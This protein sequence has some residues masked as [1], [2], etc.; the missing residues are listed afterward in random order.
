MDNWFKS[1]W[2]VRTISLAFAVVLYVFV[3]VEVSQ[4][5]NDPRIFTGNSDSIETLSDVPL[6]IRI[7]EDKYV[8]SGVPE[9]VTVTLEGSTGTL[10]AAAKQRNFD[11][12][13]NLE[14]LGEGTHTVEVQAANAPED[15]QLYIE[16]KTIE[17]TIKERASEEFEVAV[18]FIN[19]D[20]LPQGYEVGEMQVEPEKVTI[21]SSKEIIDQIAIVKVF[22]DVS[23]LKES[24]DNREVP[25]NVYNARGKELSVRVEPGSV[26]VSAE[27]RNPSKTVPVNIATTGELPEGYSLASLSANIDEVK[28]FGTSD[29][30]EGI[31]EVSTKEINLSDIK[32]SGTV[33][34]GLDLP[35]NVTTSRS[36]PIE[37]SIELEQT[38]KVSNVPINVENAGENEEITFVEPEQSQMEVTVI[39]QQN[40]IDRLTAEDIEMSINVEGL[41]EG[42]HEVPVNVNGPENVEIRPAYGQVTV[43]IS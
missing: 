28:I 14:G 1:P 13:V 5:Q 22:V 37:V 35:K 36:D 29:V 32:E 31:E 42:E 17:V 11:I 33:N 3:Q 10:T 30:L 19:T 7:D 15:L 26:T 6:E 23:G 9:F 27:I 8:V 16:P 43:N 39:G 41:D 40:K 12:Y 34:I 18:D 4:Y 25:V 24:I 38:K 21:T 2:F 20:Q